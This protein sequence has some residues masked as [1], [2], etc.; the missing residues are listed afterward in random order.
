MTGCAILLPAAGASSRMRGGDKLLEQVGD[1]P[2]LRM[3]AQR[4][5]ALGWP[6]AVTLRP[7]DN[8]RR[9]CLDGLGLVQIDVPDAAAGMSASLR[10]GGVWAAGTSADALLIALPDMPGIT[11]DDL[12]ALISAQAQH[13]DQPLRAAASDGTPGHPV[14]LPRAVWPLLAGLTGDEGARRIFA[15]HTPRLHRLAGTRAVQDLDTPEDWALWR[16]TTPD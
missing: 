6:V 14:I 11:S 9:A 16:N 8:A 12:R 2:V 7:A 10:A 5:L 1:A 4:A 15:A 3:M 13:P